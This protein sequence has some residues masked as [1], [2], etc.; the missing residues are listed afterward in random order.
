MNLYVHLEEHVKPYL[1]IAKTDTTKHDLLNLLNDSATALLNSILNV[2]DL[3]RHTVTDERFDGG[4]SMIWCKDFPVVSVTSI[5]VGKNETLYTQTAAYV[6]DK[7]K[8]LLDGSVDGGT[9]Y[10]QDKITYVAGYVTYDQ[11]QTGGTFPTVDENMPEDLKLA[12]LIL[13][14]GMFNQRNNQGVTTMSIQGK[15]ITF[16][17]E[18]EV[19]EFER[20][21]MRYKKIRNFEI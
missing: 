3:A 15:A 17:N 4:V 2:N 21:V 19:K 13:I 7:N 1:G 9:G 10:E 14:A 5:K 20:I 11:T 12:I 16:R 8:V 6:L 18:I